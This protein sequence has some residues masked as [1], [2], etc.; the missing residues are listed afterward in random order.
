MI[1]HININICLIRQHCMQIMQWSICL[2]AY[3]MLSNSW[4]RCW[5]AESMD[6]I[7]QRG[8]NATTEIKQIDLKSGIHR[9]AWKN[10]TFLLIFYTENC[11]WSSDK[12]N[13]VDFFQDLFILFYF[14]KSNI[15]SADNCSHSEHFPNQL[16]IQYLFSKLA[17]C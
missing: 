14:F 9:L 2:F 1:S 3:T 4:L 17:C 8:K 13:R 12:F 15:I 6:N 5:S 10:L 11:P 7:N 16:K